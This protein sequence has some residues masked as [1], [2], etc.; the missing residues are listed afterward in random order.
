MA[1][2]DHVQAR[3]N[4]RAALLRVTGSASLGAIRY[5]CGVAMLESG[6]GTAWKGA[7]AGS[8][9]L[10][11]IQAGSSWAGDV[12]VATDTHPNADGTSTPYRIEFRKYHSA[13]AAWDDLVKVVF[14][15]R[16]RSTV[17][18]AADRDDSYAVSAELHR[19]GYYEG[20]GATVA[21][22]IANHHAALTRCVNAADAAC[23]LGAHGVPRATLRRGSGYAGGEEREDVRELQR[24]LS[25]VADGLFGARTLA[26]VIGFQVEHGLDVDG[27]VGPKTWAALLDG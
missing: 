2:L 15:N 19:T 5:L 21:K 23:A 9:N 17:L 22:R 10:G 6:Y 27:I 16:G 1:K 12:F 7:G 26:A 8:F 11:A 24:R 4:A 25:L 3:D 13:E 18:A 20:F 14:K